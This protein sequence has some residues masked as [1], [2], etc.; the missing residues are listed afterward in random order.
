MA[1][2]RSF[3]A[4]VSNGFRRESCNLAAMDA[5]AAT[6]LALDTLV[7]CLGA[8][9]PDALKITVEEMIVNRFE[10]GDLTRESRADQDLALFDRTEARAM[11]SGVW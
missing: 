9:P 3:H 5:V 8:T 11:N 6:R 4:I 1:G 7:P 10:D 2:L